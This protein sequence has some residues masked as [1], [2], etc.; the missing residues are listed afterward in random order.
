MK[1]K[2]ITY[3]LLIL[4]VGVWGYVI[5]QV[6]TTVQ[7][8]PKPLSHANR[9]IQ[10]E[11]LNMDYYKLMDSQLLQLNYRDPLAENS[12]REVY[13]EEAAY[14]D[15]IPLYDTPDFIDD[16][17]VPEVEPDI[18]YLGFVE[19]EKT[20]KQVALVAIEGVQYM[21][22]QREQQHGVTITQIAPDY[23]KVK[24]NGKT[25]TIYK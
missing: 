17:V 11:A 3:L 25:K 21:L 7:D 15:E 22:A 24:A 18:Q 19:N 13:Y 10:H 23:I 14:G 20:K 1:K 16:Y 6:V 2:T 8:G 9:N 12:E 4:V 5:F